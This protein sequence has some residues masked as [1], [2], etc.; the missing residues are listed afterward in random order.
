SDVAMISRE[1]TPEE[2]ALGFSIY[3]VAKDAVVPIVNAGNPFL[4]KILNEGLSHRQLQILFTMEK[5]P[6]WGEVY[7]IAG[8][9]PVNVYT[10]SDASGAAIIWAGFLLA[11]LKELKGINVEGDD[12]MVESILQDTNGIGYCNMIYIW[13]S[14][15]TV[16]HPGLRVLPIDLNYNGR[17]DY[18]EVL[19]DNLSE[20]RRHI[21]MGKYPHSLCRYLYL[22]IN[23]GKTSDALNGFLEYTMT[24]GQALVENAGYC[25]VPKFVLDC[26]VNKLRR[27]K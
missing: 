26:Q 17:I 24:D 16:V 2:E 4:D 9:E 21:Q 10:R 11:D 12:S 14:S 3:T 19:P 6:N 25:R 20:M 1:I 15:S 5:K 22:L 23:P 18:K 27:G 7:M 13:D 8:D